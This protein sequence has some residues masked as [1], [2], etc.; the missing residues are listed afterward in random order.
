MKAIFLSLCT[1]ILS[2]VSY[3]S[4]AQEDL[5]KEN[6]VEEFIIKKKGGKDAT[7]KIEMKDGKVMVNG[8]SLEEFNKGEDITITK[9]KPSMGN[10]FGSMFPDNFMEQFS[11]GFD[12]ESL[13]QGKPNKKKNGRPFLGVSTDEADNGVLITDVGVGSA[14]DKAGL[15][16]GDIIKAIDGEKMD[17][18]I[19]YIEYI[20]KKKVGDE[21]SIEIL[22]NKKKKTIKAT[23]EENKTMS[24]FSFKAPKKSERDL[25]DAPLVDIENP[26]WK[27]AKK[28]TQKL[29]LRIIDIK[30]GKGVQITEVE[31]E[32]AAAAAGLVKDDILVELN[33]TVITNTDDARNV[34]QENK[35]ET[36][37][38]VK[39][40]RNNQEKTLTITFKKEE[41]T[42]EL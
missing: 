32:S 18:P 40:K 1:L 2:F 15:L 26:E 29:G 42:V 30:E 5:N 22:R 37:Y 20:E 17:N 35:E 13:L 7:L 16:K 3:Q 38:P 14:A 41:K 25:F 28:P 9:K 10:D 33:G 34:I 12:L 11:F 31:P 27:S 24:D 4:F 19:N 39:I 21:I 6:E 23:L 8:K 36:S